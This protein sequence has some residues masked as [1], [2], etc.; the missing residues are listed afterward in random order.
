MQNDVWEKIGDFLNSLRCENVGRKSYIQFSELKEAEKLK[1][2]AQKKYVAAVSKLQADQRK[3]IE[4]YVEALQ[5]KA[6][7]SEEQAYCQGYID[8]IQL[9]AG[10]G[11][12]KKNPEIEKIIQKKNNDF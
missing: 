8:C 1:K 5:H 6:F 2:E 11:L 9:L 4:A 12:L 3:N 10:V 7:M